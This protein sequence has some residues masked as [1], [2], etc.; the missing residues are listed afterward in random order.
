MKAVKQGEVYLPYDTN[1]V[2][3]EVNGDRVFWEVEENGQMKVIRV[4]KKCIGKMIS[5]KS[6]G[7][8]KRDDITH[9]YKHPEGKV[10]EHFSLKKVTQA[11][12]CYYITNVVSQRR[13]L[14]SFG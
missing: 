11:M 14:V 10:E 4:D 9:E 8:D 7:S 6:A 13:F 1:F 2:F 5:T 3:A 12:Y